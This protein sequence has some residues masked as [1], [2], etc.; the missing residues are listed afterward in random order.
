MNFSEFAYS[1]V[2]KLVSRKTLPAIYDSSRNGF[3]IMSSHI[4]QDIVCN[5]F[6]EVV[7]APSLYLSVFF[8]SEVVR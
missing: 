5:T 1:C 6:P 4:V 3:L 7:C 8:E 2:S